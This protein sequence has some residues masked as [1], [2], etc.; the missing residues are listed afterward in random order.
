MTL[1]D[2]SN[3]VNSVIQKLLQYYDANKLILVCH[4]GFN[5]NATIHVAD[6]EE[7]AQT[8][9]D[10]LANST[11]LVT[12]WTTSKKL[13]MTFRNH[14]YDHGNYSGYV[15]VMDHTG[16]SDPAKIDPR[17]AALRDEEFYDES[18][19]Y[20]GEGDSDIHRMITD[21]LSKVEVDGEVYEVIESEGVGFVRTTLRKY[22]PRRIDV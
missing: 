7:I 10:L 11:D 5:R 16:I 17:I 8:L 13:L 20:I 2:R 4:H 1:M 21:P 12:I 6:T 15:E 14:W 22:V 19:Q 3:K 18:G 9:L